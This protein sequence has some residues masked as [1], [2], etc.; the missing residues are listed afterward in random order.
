MP[1]ADIHELLRRY[2]GYEAFLPQQAE[3]IDAVLAGRDAV[4]VL[5]TGGGKS[6]CYQLP[7]LALDGIAVVCSPLLALMKDQVDALRAMGIG[8]ATLNSSLTADERRAVL[9]SLRRGE[10]KLLYLS[11]ERIAMPDVCALLEAANVR[12][13]AVDEAHCVSQWGHE[14]RPEYR[15]LGALR[16]WFPDV[17][18]LAC[19]ATATPEVRGDIEA[20]LRLR[21]PARIIGSFDRPNLLYRAIYRRD[22]DAQLD[23]V[24]ERH[25]GE[26]GVVYCIRRADVDA[27][28]KRLVGRGVNA[29]PYH[30]GLSTEVRRE[31]QEAFAEERADVVVATVAF[32]MGIDRSDVRFVVHTGMPKS[33]EAYQQ[34]AGRAGRDRLEAEC[35]LFY[36]ASDPMTW[37]RMQGAPSN[38]YEA[39]ALAKLDAM[40]RYCRTLACRHHTLVE[41]FGETPASREACGACDV[42][43][44]E[45]ALLPDSTLVARK[46]LSGVARVQER[47]GTKYVAEVLHGSQNAKI[48]ANGH[49]RLSTWG[50][51]REHALADVS[52]WIDQL[53][54][55]G[56][57]ERRGEFNV[58]GLTASG[59][60][61]M[62]GQSEV[63]LALPRPAARAAKGRKSA[64]PPA[65]PGEEALF[66]DLRALR[67]T[68]AVAKRVPP[69]MVFSDATLRELAAR[70]P[71]TVAEL[72]QVRGIGEGKAKDYGVDVLETITNGVI[73]HDLQAPIA[74][75]PPAPPARVK[76][77]GERDRAVAAFARGEAPADVATAV[78]R[79]IGTVHGWLVD[80]IVAGGVTT[81]DAWVPPDT[82][83]RVEAAAASSEDLRLKPIFE[84]LGGD[85]PYDQIRV[86]LAVLKVRGGHP[87]N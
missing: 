83:V 59:M 68:F 27:V 42:C 46:I 19:T 62:K 15:Q 74:A 49:D 40:Y 76:P 86:V 72:R 10:V 34:E 60:A 23:E 78:Q 87:A 31:N 56:H 16:E 67:R 12:F 75:A 45:H 81:V 36:D 32:G 20:A 66:Q 3:A 38:A 44:G 77:G 82:F 69:Y 11:P 37:R 48:V 26:A 70:R 57:L 71:T 2:W 35:V 24:L 14:F 4:V 47:F 52:D 8:A 41:Y 17:P 29:V 53:Q 1:A 64:G 9:A 65:S 50:L 55:L 51:L 43:L 5:P 61:L 80:W 63:Q 54:G 39:A 84:A 13:F 28:C 25:A 58:L 6:V 7:A 18:I 79:S 21:D 85:V 73:A 33:L 22:L 30:A